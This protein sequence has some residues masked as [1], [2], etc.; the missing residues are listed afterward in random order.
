MVAAA[1]ERSAA[2]LAESQARVAAEAA[3]AAAERAAAEREAKR[4]RRDIERDAERGIYHATRPADPSYPV[5]L[6]KVR[7]WRGWSRAR[8]ASAMAITVEHLAEL[9]AD[10]PYVPI[11]Y[12]QARAASA[13][14]RVP[15]PNVAPHGWRGEPRQ[16]DYMD[17]A[18]RR[19]AGSQCR[20]A[21]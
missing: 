13:A 2:C 6:P 21:A 5:G 20:G 10:I 16:A 4:R 9:E 18:C 11:T 8:L 1:A 12:A 17:L 3:A 7:R 19:R 14:L 15:L